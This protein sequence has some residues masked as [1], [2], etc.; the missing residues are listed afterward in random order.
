MEFNSSGPYCSSKTIIRRNC[1]HGK[2]KLSVDR[3]SHLCRSC[4]CKVI[5]DPTVVDL[6]EAPEKEEELSSAP[7]QEDNLTI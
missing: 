3:I 7:E 5:C 2:R 4:S 1:I 6:I